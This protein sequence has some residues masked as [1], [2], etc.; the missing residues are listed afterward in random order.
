[1]AA[2]VWISSDA[3]TTPSFPMVAISMLVQLLVHGKPDIP[4]IEGDASQIQ[5][6][7]MNLVMNGAEAIQGSGTVLIRID[8]EELDTKN[9]RGFLAPDDIRPGLFVTLEVTDTGIGMSEETQARIFDPFFTT[10]FTGR[11][12]GL[13][14]VQGIVRG[15]KGALRVFSS[16]GDGTTFKFGLPPPSRIETQGKRRPLLNP[17]TAAAALFS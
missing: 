10:K 6:V 4:F 5:Q 16:R 17:S 7:I 1:M 8:T 9:I 3:P 2:W 13:A 14:A 12:L 11:G 15:H